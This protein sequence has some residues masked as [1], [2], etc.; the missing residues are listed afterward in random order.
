MLERKERTAQKAELALLSEERQRLRRHQDE[1]KRL[2]VQSL[3]SGTV[4]FRGNDRSPEEGASDVGETA[5][6]RLGKVL[7]DVFDRFAEAAARVARVDLTSLMT[8]ENLH[9]LTPVFAQL[10]LV[11]DVKGK[12]VFNTDSGPLAEIY[13]R[14]ENQY[15]YGTASTGKSLADHFSAEPFGWDFDVVRLLVVALVRAGK[16]EATSKG[17]T[18]DSALSLD[19]RNTFENNSLFRQSSFGPR[20]GDKVTFEDLLKASEAFKKAFG[21]ELPELEQSAAAAAIREEVAKHEPAL[22]EMSTCL[23]SHRLPGTEVLGKAMEHARA[24]RTGS[25]ASAI[26]SFIGC[27]SDLKEAI[28]RAAELE[29][30]L[31]EPALHDLQRG[32]GARRPVVISSNRVR[33][34]RRRSQLRSPAGGYAQARDILPRAAGHRSASAPSRPLTAIAWALPSPRGPMRTPRPSRPSSRRPAGNHLT[35]SSTGASP[36]RSKPVPRRSSPGRSPSPSCRADLDACPARLARAV[37]ELLQIQE[38][39]RLVKISAGSYF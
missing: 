31:T 22:Q 17:R 20:K 8:S 34:C 28:K 9:G 36:L 26:L 6:A 33:P 7:P 24:I 16:I 23:L 11:R 35:R 15:E 18:I 32:A 38:G 5:S 3:L 14:I 12:P 37:Q 1:L 13:S 39:E 25:E 2:L 19:A 21:K 27:H 30:T 29:R 10:G 4:F